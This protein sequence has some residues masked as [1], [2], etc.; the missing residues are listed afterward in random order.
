MIPLLGLR[1]PFS[2]TFPDSL[3]IF[4]LRL[5]KSSEVKLKTSISPSG[6][7]VFSRDGGG[8]SLQQ[9]ERRDYKQKHAVLKLAASGAGS[10]SPVAALV[11]RAALERVVAKA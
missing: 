3:G 8:F 2:R 10:Q 9:P 7:G 4:H 5:I 1:G 11:P 6:L